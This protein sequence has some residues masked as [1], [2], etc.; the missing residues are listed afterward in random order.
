MPIY[1]GTV[2]DPPPLPR[3]LSDMA[4]V[5]GIGSALWAL[6][7]VVLLAA[8]LVAGRPLDVWFTT[9]LAGAGLGALGWGIV[10]WQRA[11]V[12]RGSRGAQQGLD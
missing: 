3:R 8:W 6:G 10:R 2:A 1:P 9:C 11:A 5:V 7:A 12:R 4:T